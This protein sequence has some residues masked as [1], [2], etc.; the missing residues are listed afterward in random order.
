MRLL[1]ECNSLGGKERGLTKK[2]GRLTANLLQKRVGPNEE[3]EC[4]EIKINAR[5]LLVER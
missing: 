3:I 2:K 5:E 1:G 4:V